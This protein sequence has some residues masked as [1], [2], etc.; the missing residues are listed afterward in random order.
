MIS[1]AETEGIAETGMQEYKLSAEP[2]IA[3][4]ATF[5]AAIVHLQGPSREADSVNWTGGYQDALY[6]IRQE[7]RGHA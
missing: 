7:H 6:L 3:Y 2:W 1:L 5:Q 4:C